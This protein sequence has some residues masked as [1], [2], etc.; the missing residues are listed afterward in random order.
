MTP[1]FTRYGA[2]ALLFLAGC[3]T[4]PDAVPAGQICSSGY[5]SVADD[6]DG[7]RRGT[8]S[9]ESRRH[10]L[11][12]IAR[13]SERVTNPSPWFAMRIEPAKPGEVTIELDYGDWQH[14]YVPK[15]SS[16]G[17]NWSTLPEDAVRVSEDG[18]RA[19]IRLELG[20][21]PVWLAAQELLLPGDYERW[22]RSITSSGIG[23]IVDL[24]MSAQG[25]VV[26][27]LDGGGDS[28]EVAL[29]VGRQ[30]PPEVPGAFAM[31][32]FVET[33]F[34]DTRLASSFRERFHVV[35]IPLLNPDGVVLGHWRGNVKGTDLNRD[36]GPFEE[37]ETRL[38]R[39][40]LGRLED[41]GKVFALFVD[42]HSTKRNLFYTQVA[43]EHP[44]NARFVGRWFGRVRER[45]PEY[46]FTIEAQPTS[47]TANGKNYMFS[48]Y[49]IPSIS[50]EVGDETDRE[51]AMRAARVF[52]EEMMTLMLEGVSD[53]Q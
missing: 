32:A 19:R 50:Y 34:A 42:F 51:V 2:L 15:I 37:P 39:D 43:D 44:G 17:H 16:D 23:K 25:R 1:W 9:F 28:R 48:R 21:E 38:V 30:H 14:R 13:E 4:L 10:A 24:G 6:F 5:F 8:C 45:F 53:T 49:G 7:A 22:L 31:Q 18:A 46:V 33:I 12:E 40:L 47:E 35:A 27:M 26:Q 52:A 29:L 36:W 41:D 20:N 3:S 11:L